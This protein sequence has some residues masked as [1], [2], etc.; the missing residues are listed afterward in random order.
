MMLLVLVFSVQ[1]VAAEN[2]ESFGYWHTVLSARS[3]AQG[4]LG[5]K[6]RCFYGAASAL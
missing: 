6:G 3:V 1:G 5:C 4:T 2:E